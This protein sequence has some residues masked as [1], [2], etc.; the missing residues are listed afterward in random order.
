MNVNDEGKV[1]D[2]LEDRE[3]MPSPVEKSPEVKNL[4]R[5][6]RKIQR[7]TVDMVETSQKLV[8]GKKRAE[9]SFVNALEEFNAAQERL[10]QSAE[11]KI[12]KNCSN[13]KI[14]VSNLR[15]KGCMKKTNVCFGCFTNSEKH[16]TNIAK[17]EVLSS[18][19]A[20]IANM[21]FSD[22]EEWLFGDELGQ[23][24]LARIIAKLKREEYHHR[25]WQ[26]SIAAAAC[27]KNNY[28]N[29]SLIESRHIIERMPISKIMEHIP[30]DIEG[31]QEVVQTLKQAE[32]FIAKTNTNLDKGLIYIVG[33]SL[34]ASLI[35]LTLKNRR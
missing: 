19:Y 29:T 17:D 18:Q 26:V 1:Q 20:Q 30:N 16:K 10:I 6:T 27:S 3:E 13:C 4:E 28:N 7:Q 23:R 2:P 24:S 31:I 5:D 11:D 15:D 35:P 33:A 34:L 12:S 8:D 9:E 14:V 32:T 22:Y 25:P 21:D